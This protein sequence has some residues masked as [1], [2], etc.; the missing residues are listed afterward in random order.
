MTHRESPAFA[1][2]SWLFLISATHA[3]HP[4]VGPAKSE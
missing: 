2:I 4:H 1:T 3:V